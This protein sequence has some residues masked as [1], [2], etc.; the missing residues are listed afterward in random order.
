MLSAGSKAMG[1]RSDIKWGRYGILS[2][3]V[4][5]MAKYAPAMIKITIKIKGLY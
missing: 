3:R 1:M 5:I 2:G 4:N